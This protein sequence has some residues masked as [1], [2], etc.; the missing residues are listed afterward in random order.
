MKIFVPSYGRADCS[1]T[2]GLIPSAKIV[3]PQ[4]QLDDYEKNYPGRVIAVDDS[5]DGSSPKKKNA[6]LS[7]MEEG[8]LAWVLDDDLKDVYNI[9]KQ[10]K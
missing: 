8:E 6:I 9:K 3:V 1:T 4:S 10:Q 5:Q 7:L 2:M